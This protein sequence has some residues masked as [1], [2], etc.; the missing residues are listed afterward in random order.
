MSKMC[1]MGRNTVK[2]F[3]FTGPRK[4]R[5]ENPDDKPDS[6]NQD[7]SPDDFF[8][9][10]NAHKAR[11]VAQNRG[12]E[13][14]PKQQNSAGEKHGL[15]NAD[16]IADA[17]KFFKDSVPSN[18]NAPKPANLPVAPQ[19]KPSTM[20][21]DFFDVAPMRSGNSAGVP[22][23]SSSE[24][25]SDA[26]AADDA[27]DED[28]VVG[29]AQ[30]AAKKKA[31]AKAGSS[32]APARPAVKAKGKVSRP[33]V[34]DDDD[35]DDDDDDEE[36]AEEESKPL[37]PT[38]LR[39]D[40]E[41]SPMSGLFWRQFFAISKEVLIHPHTFFEALPY[42][43]GFFEPFIYLATQSVLYSLIQAILKG[44]PLVFVS[45]LFVSI[46]STVAGA[47][48][49][50]LLFQKMGGKGTLEG[51]YRIFVYSKATLLFS[52]LSLGPIP[53]GGLLAVCYTVYL[54]WIGMTRHHELPG[55][56]TAQILVIMAVI[57]LA[58]KFRIG[59]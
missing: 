26:S 33:V 24:V 23:E 17:D 46:V 34:E 4:L 16:D 18:L 7:H 20:H 59:G 44:N 27:G 12:K 13:E 14:T 8:A 49:V 15:D 47:F 29:G 43:G 11:D 39:D 41:R 35:D 5:V 2:A 36:G 53:I 58:L 10:S 38:V 42:E 48:A 30:P 45:S 54:N 40:L 56:V 19:P 25:E 21:Q 55:K 9:S 31:S 52:W 3:Q 1:L 6:Q 57:G 28:G 22:V 32:K 37:P 50:G 51:T